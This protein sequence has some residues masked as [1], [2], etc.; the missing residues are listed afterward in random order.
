MIRNE[1]RWLKEQASARKETKAQDEAILRRRTPLE[2]AFQSLE[3]G[4][5]DTAYWRLPSGYQLVL[6][7][8]WFEY[9]DGYMD[10]R[11]YDV[12]IRWYGHIDITGC[13]LYYKYDRGSFSNMSST[14]VV[15]LATW[16]EKYAA[17]KAKAQ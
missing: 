2:R 4:L 11:T 16:I 12:D 17:D 5:D 13:P 10:W 15:H 1:R 6:M 9:E 7:H 14:D 8:E 3:F